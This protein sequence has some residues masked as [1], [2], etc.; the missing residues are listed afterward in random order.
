ASEAL[1]LLGHQA[2]R[3]S[4]EIVFDLAQP[5]LRRF[6]LRRNARCRHDHSLVHE[7]LTVRGTVGEML[8]AL[9]ERFG[10]QPVRIEGRRALGRFWAPEGLL[11][12]AGESLLARGLVVGDR[13]RAVTKNGLVWLEVTN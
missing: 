4:Y 12:H 6:T 2:P 11:P 7:V 3:E 8:E 5:H 9:R 10:E 13:L 1:R